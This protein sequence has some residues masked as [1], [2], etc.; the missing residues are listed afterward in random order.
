LA[1][2]F[3]ISSLPDLLEEKAIFLPSVEYEEDMSNRVEDMN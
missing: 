2:T 1:G 3:Q